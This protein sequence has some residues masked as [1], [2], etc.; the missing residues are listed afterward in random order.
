M[1]IITV[2][3]KLFTFASSLVGGAGINYLKIGVVAALIIA[4]FTTYNYITGIIEDNKELNVKLALT[5]ADLSASESILKHTVESY[6][7]SIHNLDKLSQDLADI[8]IKNETLERSLE[9]HD[10]EFLAKRK[11]GLISTRINNASN[12]VFSDLEKASRE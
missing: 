6:N 10:L 11:P 7:Q 3:S 9:K 4:C 8:Q 2:V 5:R 1:E 12:R